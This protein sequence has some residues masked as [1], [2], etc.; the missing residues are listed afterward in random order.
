MANF[1]LTGLALSMVCP[2]NKLITDDRG[3]PGVY[4]ERAAQPLSALLA[5]GDSSIHPA[6]LINGIQHDKIAIGKF[7]AKT[8][9]NRAYSLPGEDPTT[10]ITF[11]ASVQACKNKGDGH[12]LITAAE[13]A[14][15]ALLA[16]KNGTMPKGNNNYG[17]DASETLK[18]AIP[19]SKDNNGATCRVATG[20]G[21]ATWSDTGDISGIYDLNGNI[22]EWVSGMRLV[23]GELQVIPYNNAADPECDTS[24][25]STQWRAINAAATNYN[26]LFIAPNGQGTTAGS[27]KLDFV[28]NHWQWA[29]TITSQSDS[30]RN[31]LFASTTALGLSDFTKK[32]MQAM[33][34][35]P[36]DGATA[37]DYAGDNFWGN[38]GADERLPLRGGGWWNTSGAGVF[39][40]SLADPRGTSDWNVGFRAAFENL[41][42]GS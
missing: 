41:Q 42:S 15:L 25:A 40:L 10:Y 32:Y 9:S 4:V 30:S 36:E 1:D 26:D 3:L 2:T 8:H 18:I 5:G 21:P 35:L 31:A 16:K 17:K 29:V 19:T 38:N 11:D 37:D 12:H 39:A 22:W 14:F 28:S 13:W 34:L 27:V 7:Q 23:K 24:A 20:T 33:A 6:F